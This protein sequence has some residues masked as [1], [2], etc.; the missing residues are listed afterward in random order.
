MRLIEAMFKSNIFARKVFI[1]IPSDPLEICA[2]H[3]A[4]LKWRFGL[5]LECVCLRNWPREAV[6]YSRPHRVLFAIITIYLAV[7]AQSR[8]KT[9]V[10]L[11]SAL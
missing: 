1:S 9:D 2:S 11:T 3:K 7:V 8:D 5:P 10:I 6:Q 4:H